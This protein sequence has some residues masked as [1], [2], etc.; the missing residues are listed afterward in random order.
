M[1]KQAEYLTLINE[2]YTSKQE[3]HAL[4]LVK[5]ILKKIVQL[6][7]TIVIML[8][9][10]L[11]LALILLLRKLFLG[12]PMFETM[13]II[14]H[15]SIKLTLKLYNLQGW[16][17]KHSALG[18]KL[19]KGE[20]H[21]VGNSFLSEKDVKTDDFEIITKF[22][23]PGIFNLWF[24]RESTKIAHE[25]LLATEIE[26]LATKSFKK[27]LSIILKTFPALVYRSDNIAF[28]VELT[29]FDLDFINTTMKKAIEII[30]KT[31][32]SKNKNKFFFV[33]PDCMNKL[34]KDKEYFA[35]MQRADYIFPDGIG[36]SIAC[37]ILKTPLLENVN[38]TDMLPYLCELSEKREYKIFL[39]G[40]KPGIAEKMKMSLEEKYPNLK[41]VGTQSGYFD[42]DKDTS[43]IID[44]INASEADILLVAFGVPLQE[45]WIDENFERLNPQVQMGVGGLFDFYSGDM[46]RAPKW[47]REIG[48]EWL[49]RLLMEPKR[50][51]KR[52]VIGNPLFLYRVYK[53]KRKSR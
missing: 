34:Y 37:N 12:K 25:G 15:N 2:K 22:G 7:F 23:Y 10:T 33:N 44:K 13:T 42:W 52:Y 4:A 17:F 29:I 11:P 40:A 6:A 41:I 46:K 53:W 49:F 30:D 21:F 51:W 38:G 26:Y 14:G 19:I 1:N 32:K 3:N 28:P 24:I 31:I 9:L 18:F 48:M 27:D 36:I 5:A 43:P 20:I 45:K 39:F 50:M 35:I 8:V 16:I 47:M